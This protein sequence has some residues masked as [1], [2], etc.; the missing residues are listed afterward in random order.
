MTLTPGYFVLFYLSW[1]RVTHVL[2]AGLQSQESSH[3]SLTGTGQHT[4]GPP[5]SFETY[6]WL[7]SPDSRAQLGTLNEKRN[8]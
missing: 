3:F 6:S 2:Q 8:Q 7:G 1:E 5:G 4:Q